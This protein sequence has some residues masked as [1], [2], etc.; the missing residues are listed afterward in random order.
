MAKKRKRR[1]GHITKKE[2]DL[3]D[4]AL[5]K[6]ERHCHEFKDPLRSVA[7]SSGVMVFH[8]ALRQAGFRLMFD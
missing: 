6:A 3:V 5:L 4:K 2:V 7:C 8:D 1:L